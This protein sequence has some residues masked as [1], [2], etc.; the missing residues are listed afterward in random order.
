MKRIAVGVLG[1]G[2]V[3]SGVVH[4]L[5]EYQT[6]LEEKTGFSIIIKKI[7][8]QEV[9]KER[10]VEV[11]KELLTTDSQDILND[12]EIKIVIELIG[13]TNEAKEIIMEALRREKHVITANKDLMALYGEEILQLADE[14]NC[15][16]GYEASVGGGIPI[17]RSLRE[18]LASDQVYKIMGIVN[19]TTNYIL[20]N[21]SKNSTPFNEALK[22]AQEKGYAEQD[23]ASDILGLD[24]ARKMVILSRIAFNSK[25]ELSDLSIKGINDVTLE[26]INYAKSFGYE[27]KLLGIAEKNDGL[28]SVS[29]EPCFVNK[30]HPIASI[31]GVFNAIYVYGKAVG[32]T[33]F[34]GPG[35]GSY[36][37]A[38]AVLSDLLSILQSLNCEKQV[39]KGKMEEKKLK[40][41]ELQIAKYFIRL[42]VLDQ[43]GVLSH[44]TNLFAK[45][46]IS[47]EKII[48]KPLIDGSAELVL[49]THY[50]NL[51]SLKNLQ[52]DL[53]NNPNI[54]AIKSIYRVE[55]EN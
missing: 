11:E 15:E 19:G 14:K 18:G 35:A 43:T 28:I 17:I 39:H 51:Q 13:G 22:E 44:I 54:I 26:D 33:M 50:A 36:P 31:D 53:A 20:S 41:A 2:T 27:V 48:Q 46:E 23:P 16:L 4:L 3:G 12:S 49:I 5:K 1:L 55:G 47:M 25:V 45:N 32:E 38:T 8:I 42:N 24:A 7:L 37:T 6:Y 30:F 9:E 21:M 34:Y 40:P 10:N 52:A 29:V